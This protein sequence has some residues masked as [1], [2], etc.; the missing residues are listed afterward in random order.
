MGRISKTVCQNIKLHTEFKDLRKQS[1]LILSLNNSNG[2]EQ[3]FQSVQFQM[4]TSNVF[5]RDISID[6]SFLFHTFVHAKIYS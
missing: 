4:T 3:M 5:F 6:K 2:L 1:V